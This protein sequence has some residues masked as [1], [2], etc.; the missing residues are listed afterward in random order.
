MIVY[1]LLKKAFRSD[2]LKHIKRVIRYR[3]ADQMSYVTEHIARTLKEAREKK[4]LSQRAL[5]KKAGV[6]QSHISKI[7]GG[8]VDLRLSSLIEL[9]RGLDLELALVPRK[10]VPA[11]QSIVRSSAAS[12]LPDINT[13]S[14][15]VKELNRIQDTLATFSKARQATNEFA[16]LQRQLKDF[17][18][19]RINDSALKTFRDAQKKLEAL[20]G[21]AQAT[22]AIRQFNL[23]FKNL[24]NTLA[25][26]SSG[27]RKIEPVRPAYSL[28]EEDDDV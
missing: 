11:V 18:H 14:R 9:A 2:I 1:Q 19:F 17:Q 4:G 15:A 22:D 6:P 20:K 21:G 13:A 25:H 27:N 3:I 8:A 16:Q 23:Q 5:S 26:S 12:T 28:D 7:E 24:R 10:A